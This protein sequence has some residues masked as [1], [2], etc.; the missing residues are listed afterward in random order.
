MVAHDPNHL[1]VVVELAS[2]ADLD[3]GEAE[4]EALVE[5]VGMP[6]GRL[7]EHRR[8]GAVQ[9]DRM[10]RRS[11]ELVDRCVEG[12]AGDVP[13]G[14]LDRSDRLARDTLPAEVSVEGDRELGESV[15]DRQRIATDEVARAHVVDDRPEDRGVGVAPVRGCLAPPDRAVVGLDPHEREAPLHRWV[16][17]AVAGEHGSHALDPHRGRGSTRFRHR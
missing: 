9:R 2:E 15:A 3:A 5:V 7:F 17:L 13:E 16:A 12:F 8:A 6:L 14:D 4:R 10:R 1:D 11:E